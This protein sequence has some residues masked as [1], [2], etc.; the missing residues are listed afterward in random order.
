MRMGYIDGTITTTPRM[1]DDCKDGRYGLPA[2]S[3][4][5]SIPGGRRRYDCRDTGGR[6]THDSRDGGGRTLSGTSVEEQ[7]PRAWSGTRAEVEPRRTVMEK[8]KQA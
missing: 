4:H 7:L 1:D 5:Y 3:R 6:A 8:N 2:L